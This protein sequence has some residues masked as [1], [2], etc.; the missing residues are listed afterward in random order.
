VVVRSKS[1]GRRILDLLSFAP[2]AIPGV[3]MGV[4]LTYVYL[5]ISV[6]PIYGTIWI[7][8]IAY[9]TYYIA[10]GSRA[11]RGVMLQMHPELEEAGLMSGASWSRTL[12]K[13]TFPLIFPTV[14]SVWI[15]VMAHAMREL[16]SAL[17]LKG[18]N[19]VVLTTLL[20]D[21]W[22]GG[23][24]NKAAA[25]GVWLMMALVLAVAVWQFTTSRRSSTGKRD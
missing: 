13:V 9:I 21:Y 1:V 2:V 3:M 20:W 15:W 12:R 17:M 25:T 8:A 5:T 11:F 18:P 24:P 23:E 22:S 4:A 14:F 6:V 16:S 10:Y 19:N 7:I